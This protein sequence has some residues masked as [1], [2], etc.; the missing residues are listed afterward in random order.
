MFF[1]EHPQ[2]GLGPL[3]QGQLIYVFPF[4]DAKRGEGFLPADEKA[5]VV[6]SEEERRPSVAAF[7]FRA[8]FVQES[9]PDGFDQEVEQLG[10]HYDGGP[11]PRFSLSFHTTSIIFQIPL[12]RFSRDMGAFR[13]VALAPGSV[14]LD[15]KAFH[16]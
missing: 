9:V 4:G 13:P 6:P 1:Q 8:A 10:L 7:G 3:R 15:N 12:F 5:L 14:L 16:L 2:G 11:F